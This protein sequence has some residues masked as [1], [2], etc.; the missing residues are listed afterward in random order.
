M[1]NLFNHLASQPFI[2]ATAFAALVH[3]TWALGTLFAGEAPSVTWSLA[4]AD[5]GSFALELFAYSYWITPALAIA[6]ALDV[7][8]VKTAHDIQTGERNPVKYATFA[9]FALATYYLQFVYI[10]HHFPTLE[11]G[12]GVAYP[13]VVRAV[14]N[15]GLWIIPA[16]LPLS[17]MLYTLSHRSEVSASNPVITV[18]DTSPAKPKVAKAKL[19]KPSK[20]KA[21]PAK[22][23][24]TST[25][26]SNDTSEH[27][28]ANPDGTYTAS[29]PNC[30]KV[31]SRPTERKAKAALAGHQAHC[32]G[33]EVALAST[34]VVELSETNTQD[35]FWDNLG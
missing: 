32:K 11:L 10:A 31:Y 8:Q 2:S 1:K 14:S 6:F 22:V 15:A 25:S 23:L 5:T 16:L 12:A 13:G 21:I 30:N 27:I 20:A 28:V 9:I 33:K 35:T 19:P 3:S 18:E 34:P 29:C 24:A 7:G 26:H 4:V 17:T